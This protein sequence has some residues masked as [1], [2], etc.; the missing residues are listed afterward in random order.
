M[1]KILYIINDDNFGGGSQH[2]LDL[3]ENIDRKKFTPI[4]ISTNDDIVKHLKQKTKSYIVKMKSSFDKNA[5]EKIQSIIKDEKPEMIHLHSTRA[6]ILGTV[7]VKNTNIPVIYTEHLYTKEYQ[8][9][10]K[11]IYWLQLKT[12]RKLSSNI[13]KVI[14]VSQAVKDFS[15]SKKVFSEEKIE[16]IYNGIKSCNTQHVTHSTNSGQACNK[17]KII[18]GSIGALEPIK[19]YKY[20]LEAIGK[21]KKENQMIYNKIQVE[22]VGEGT[23]KE[24]LKRLA[25]K[26]KIENK[27]K[28][29]GQIKN[30]E[31]EMQNWDLYIQPSLSESFGLA[32]AKAMSMGISSIATNVG[33]MSEIINS[34]CGILVPAKDSEKLAEAIIRL[35][36]NRDLNLRIGKNGRQRIIQKFSLREM[37]KKTEELY[38]K[39]A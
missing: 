12:F 22:I 31:K 3:L 6:G 29:S 28:F 21:I 36:R 35:V 9:K 24:K 16:M 32:L 1:K 19:G 17:D 5:I 2:V 7:A 34:N 11:F 37:I 33:G 15:V 4:I 13:T 26:L 27:I 8:S 10:N 20:L 39:I 18:I 38:E 14:A 30:I 23:E 25:Q